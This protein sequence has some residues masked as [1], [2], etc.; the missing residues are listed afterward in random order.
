[1]LED[2]SVEKSLTP[3]GLSSLRDSMICFVGR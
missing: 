1:M 2:L 3:D